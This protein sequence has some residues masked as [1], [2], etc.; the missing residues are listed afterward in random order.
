M[1]NALNLLFQ[2]TPNFAN[3]DLSAGANAAETDL[4]ADANNVDD[5]KDN[6]AQ[7]LTGETA[8]ASE[9][10][11]QKAII[12]I[13]SQ[14]TLEVGVQKQPEIV[15]DKL[16]MALSSNLF[17]NSAPNLEQ[18]QESSPLN[19]Y[20]GMNLPASGENLPPKEALSAEVQA[21]V[22][23]A[24]N[25]LFGISTESQA[26]A[27]EATGLP[28][29]TIADPIFEDLAFLPEES[30]NSLQAVNTSPATANTENEDHSPQF[31]LV[32][33]PL[34]NGEANQKQLEL[35]ERII[36]ADKE[37]VLS[38]VQKFGAEQR[39]N[40]RFDSVRN[41]AEPV[42]EFSIE[43]TPAIETTRPISNAINSV[44][45]NL[46][47]T[48]EAAP[49]GNSENST[50]PTGIQS[51]LVGTGKSE[52][53]S[54]LVD[55]Q[56]PSS[57]ARVSVPL[58][59]PGWNDN[60]GRQLTLLVSKNFDSAQIQLEPPELGPLQVR[61]QIQND[62]V[63]LQ[64]VSPHAM[65][66]DAVEQTIA[67]L[68]EMFGEEGLELVDVNVSDEDQTEGREEG[69]NENTSLADAEE[70]DEILTRRVPLSLDD[71]KIDYFI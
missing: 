65:V 49:L 22:D 16:S 37:Q 26:S 28:V 34:L 36:L 43:R 27:P 69:K 59:Q 33:P 56:R 40:E 64:F 68:Q 18:A 61:F 20:A 32:A 42:P 51:A 3:K 44:M 41:R 15:L 35:D 55:S 24:V 45:T 31:E 19:L 48:A 71:G 13:P 9:S 54:E 70:S 29:E 12:E 38:N 14:N 47:G 8:Q 46:V 5:R 50:A 11:N 53:N 52:L 58:H 21:L 6:F 7:L 63:S 10:A 2:G 4:S 67:R 62:Q 66:R 60:L 25:K 39:R 17:F 57:Q 23:S 30:S 1:S